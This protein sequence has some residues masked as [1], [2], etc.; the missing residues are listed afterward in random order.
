MKKFDIVIIGGGFAGACLAN[1]LS[2]L[3]SSLEILII[4][5]KRL[6]GKPVSAFT[7]VDVLD[8]LGIRNAAR[9]YYNQIEI[10]STLGAKES[11][12]YDEDVFA[13]IDYK[14]TCDELVKRSGCKVIFEYVKS[15]KEAKIILEDEVVCPKI[16]VDSSGRGYKFRKEL[17]CDVPKI[18]NHLYFKKF[19]HCDIANPKSIHLVLGD[20]GTNGGWFYPINE[21][22][23]EMGVAERTSKIRESKDIVKEQKKNME[24]FRN[25]SPYREM[26]KSSIAEAEAMVHYPYEPVKQVVKG[27]VVFLGDNAGMV[28]PIHG[29][30]IH[31]INKIGTL[32]AEYCVQAVHGNTMMLGGYQKAWEYMLKRD[33][34]EWVQG[35]TYWS[36]NK[37]QLNK[38][39][40]IR[41]NSSVNKM[42][43]IAELRGH[44]G[45]ESPGDVFKVPLGL[46][47]TLVKHFLINKIKYKLK[48]GC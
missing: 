23:C 42:N 6:G 28:H 1:K 2:K 30:G 17:K 18:E 26:L 3:D 15:I 16:I 25:Y 40:E 46:Y 33:E 21:R 11:Y 7:F 36:L 44:G 19:S 22:E 47:L 13:L 14:K 48:Y 35:M 39:I 27:N 20:I 38:I 5:G 4:E 32:C 41:S 8:D 31:Y 45:N 43:V 29:M 12:T 34:N 10:V 37:E 24:T 9:Q